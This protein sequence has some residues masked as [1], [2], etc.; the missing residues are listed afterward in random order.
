MKRLLLLSSSRV[1]GGGYLDHAES[2]IR[3]FLQGVS[4][5]LFVP[6]ALQDREGYA[7][8]AR[9]RFSVLGIALDSIHD[10]DDPKRALESAQAIFIGGGNTFRLLNTLYQLDLLEAVRSRVN[11]GMPYMG[12]S[13]GSNVAGLTIKTTNDMPI[14]Y[15]P[16]FDALGLVPFQ[17]NPHYID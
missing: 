14:I 1:H 2:E 3:V 17:I 7:S 9:Q 11:V 13:A 12:A 15:P 10:A 6:Y 8:T 4:R 5:I 16:S